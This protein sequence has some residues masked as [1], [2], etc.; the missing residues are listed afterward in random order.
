MRIR[1]LIQASVPAERARLPRIAIRR[2]ALAAFCALPQSVWAFGVGEAELLSTYAQ[3][4]S[5]RVPITLT[6]PDE[7]VQSSDFNVRLLPFSAYESLGV[8]TPPVNPEKVRVTVA[9]SGSSYWVEL[10]SPQLIR[11]PFMT[12]LLE[13][14]LAG[15]RV[16]RELPILFD[17]PADSAR[18]VVE[19]GSTP[20]SAESA[21]ET[22]IA[23]QALD[24]TVAAAPQP[25]APT[26][27]VEPAPAAAKPRKKVRAATPVVKKPVQPPKK[28]SSFQLADWN[29]SGAASTVVLRRFQLAES[30]S[31][32]AQLA[33]SGAAPTPAT[34]LTQAQPITQAVAPVAAAPAPAVA[35]TP[36]TQISPVAAP[37]SE[38]TGFTWLWWMLAG[39]LAY[40]LGTFL[41]RRRQQPKTSGPAAVKSPLIKPVKIQIKPVVTSQQPEVAVTPPVPVVAV[42]EIVVAKPDPILV[43]S[44]APTATI[45]AVETSPA[46]PVL[47]DMKR[48]LT[49]FQTRAIHDSNLMR[50][51]QLVDAYLDLNRIESADLLLT[52]LENE[53]SN[54][55][56]PKISLIKG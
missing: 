2:F 54:P 42:P 15:V 44:A 24:T 46:R 22:G 34:A 3:P 8:S 51:A 17:L 45:A 25:V 53:I 41:L 37:A 19:V 14:R 55:A 1:G 52:E 5:A 27:L 9:G 6:S 16:V 26:A 49:D 31:S 21:P 4:L 10:Y 20:L 32:Y 12:L 50:K 28:K 35:L 13:V 18:P 23:V 47:E 29:Q 11:E 7:V 30:F 39:G 38:K 40:A 48:R 33:Q 36:A 56:R 43:P